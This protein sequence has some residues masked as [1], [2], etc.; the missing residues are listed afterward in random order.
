MTQESEVHHV[1]YNM[2]LIEGAVSKYVM[3][4]H[5]NWVSGV[6][7]QPNSSTVFVCCPWN[8]LDHS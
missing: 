6:A 2:L 1:S 4:G 7:W 3:K 8:V 5:T